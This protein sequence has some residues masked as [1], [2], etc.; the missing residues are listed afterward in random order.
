MT[1]F[2]SIMYVPLGS[3]LRLSCTVNSSEPNPVWSV[4]L[5][6]TETAIQFTFEQSINLLNSRGFYLVL[7]LEESGRIK[8]T[9]LLING[10]AGETDTTIGCVDA[11]R[12]HVYYETCLFIYGESTYS[13]S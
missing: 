4:H 5:E 10:T 6:G 13:N 9:Q 2:K 7:A 11:S 8:L 1:P 3:S 12:A